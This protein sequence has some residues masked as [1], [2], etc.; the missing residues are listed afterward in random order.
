MQKFLFCCNLLLI[1]ALHAQDNSL[2]II[3]KDPITVS[4]ESEDPAFDP[5]VKAG[6]I[7]IILEVY[8][9][10]RKDFNPDAI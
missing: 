1:P 5:A 6:L 4:F 9:R 10:L 7:N 3:D 8:P 2:E